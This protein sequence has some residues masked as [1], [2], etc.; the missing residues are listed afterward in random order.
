MSADDWG[1]GGWE[2]GEAAAHARPRALWPPALLPSRL[3]L[4]GVPVEW[5]CGAHIKAHASSGEMDI[6]RGNG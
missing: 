2:E 6:Y 1:E 4:R 5:G 3:G